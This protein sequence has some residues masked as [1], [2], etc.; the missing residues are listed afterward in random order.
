MS[1]SERSAH[2]GRMCYIQNKP[3][4]VQLATT[5]TTSCLHTQAVPLHILAVQP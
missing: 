1:V 5:K 4:S 2:N 3:Y